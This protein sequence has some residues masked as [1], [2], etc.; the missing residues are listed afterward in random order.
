MSNLF[1]RSQFDGDIISKWDVSNVQDMSTMFRGIESSCT[2][3]DSDIWKWDV[4]RVKE[5]S[6]MFAIATNKGPSVPAGTS[7]GST[8]VERAPPNPSPQQA[9]Q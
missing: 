1:A 4:S 9:Q 8:G 3:F 7:T 6:Y 5:M 2:L